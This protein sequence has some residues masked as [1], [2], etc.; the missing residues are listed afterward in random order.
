MEILDR[1]AGFRDGWHLLHRRH[2]VDRKEF[3]LRGRH[4]EVADSDML[5]GKKEFDF[6]GVEHRVLHECD[7]I[8]SFCVTPNEWKVGSRHVT[9]LDQP[10][11]LFST[12]VSVEF[13]K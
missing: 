4:C 6:E 2:G 9:C 8:C 5:R 10:R 3:R 12:N 7:M 11:C 1:G 13:N